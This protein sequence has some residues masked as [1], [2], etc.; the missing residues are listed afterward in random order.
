A[1][2]SRKIT[3]EGNNRRET[4]LL[5]SEVHPDSPTGRD[6]YYAQLEG[7]NAL[8]TVKIPSAASPSAP[9]GLMD[10]LRTAQ[11]SLRETRILDF[12][13]PAVTAI[14][15][16]APNQPELILQRLE[17]GTQAADNSSWQIVLRGV[18]T[19]GPQTLPADRAAVQRLLD[20]LS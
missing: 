19:V 14:T 4:L 2:A 1:G 8:F 12:D 20:Q 16:A 17:T 18:S 7:R 3:L 11:V 9:P 13:P 10:T 15:L 6:E 5:G